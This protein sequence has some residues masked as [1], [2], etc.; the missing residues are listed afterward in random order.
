MACT[1]RELRRALTAM[2]CRMVRDRDGEVRVALANGHVD[3]AF[4]PQPVR[5]LGALELPVLRVT[6][7]FVSVPS[8]AREAFLARFDLHTRRGGG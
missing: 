1:P 7:R 8:G 5:R 3:I 4:A 2:D 6:M